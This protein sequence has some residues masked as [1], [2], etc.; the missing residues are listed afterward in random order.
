MLE[1]NNSPIFAWK[2]NILKEHADDDQNLAI[3][4]VPV[5]SWPKKNAKVG[6]QSDGGCYHA[7]YFHIL[8][9]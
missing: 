4:G 6:L 5:V 1:V 8:W 3:S 2:Q 7:K 9:F